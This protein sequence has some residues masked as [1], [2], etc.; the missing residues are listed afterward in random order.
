VCNRLFT[1]V[2]HKEKNGRK[3]P[4]SLP[5]CAELS[6]P[7]RQAHHSSCRPPLVSQS[8]IRNKLRAYVRQSQGCSRDAYGVGFG[9]A[10]PHASAVQCTAIHPPSLLWAKKKE[11]KEEKGTPNRDAAALLPTCG[12]TKAPTP[13][14]ER[15]ENT[16]GWVYPHSELGGGC[17]SFVPANLRNSLVP[18]PAPT[19]PPSSIFLWLNSLHLISFDSLGI[20]GLGEIFFWLSQ[21]IQ[22][23]H[24]KKSRWG[25]KR[26]ATE[27]GSGPFSRRR[28]KG[29]Q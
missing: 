20:A 13:H 17:S 11:K 25:E 26:R 14:R 6:W 10:G 21:G 24:T 7:F 27:S 16:D 18:V 9:A 29:K 15:M 23:E 2:R 12:E 1:T 22:I 19:P 4:D 3:T 8:T 5:S 28:R